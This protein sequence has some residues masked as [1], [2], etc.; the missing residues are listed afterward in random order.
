ML[1]SYEWLSEYVDLNGISPKDLAE[2]ITRSG[3]E[4]EMVQ[5]LDKEIQNVVVGHVLSKEKHPEA[6]KLN[7]CMVDVGEENPLQIVCGAANVAAGQKVAVAKVGAVLPGNFKIKKAKLRGVVSNGMICSLAE[8]GMETKV[9][10]KEYSAGIFNFPSDTKIGQNAMEALGFQD[11]VLELGLTPNRSD[12]LSMIGVAY[13][14]AA[15]L[16]EKVH[17][18]VPQYQAGPKSTTELIQA[19]VEVGSPLCAKSDNKCENRS[20]SNV[21]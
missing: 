12:C 21:A 16:N 20:L 6:D 3:I 17:L 11:A 5:I 14:V 4:V 2:K 9:V 13:E 7:I 19:K 8:L 1:V 10:A 18:N 15:L